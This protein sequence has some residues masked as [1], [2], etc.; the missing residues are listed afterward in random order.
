MLLWVVYGCYLPKVTALV[1][2]YKFICYIDRSGYF[3]VDTDIFEVAH[4]FA[5]IFF[6]YYLLTGDQQGYHYKIGVA[7]P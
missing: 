5:I 6:F 7:D 3:D 4:R 1:K 2:L